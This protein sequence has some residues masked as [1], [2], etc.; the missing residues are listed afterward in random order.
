MLY[1]VYR[2]N[3]Y[4]F[5]IANIRQYITEV[6]NGGLSPRITVNVSWIGVNLGHDGDHKMWFYC[7]KEQEVKRPEV[8]EPVLEI[9][10]KEFSLLAHW[11]ECRNRPLKCMTSNDWL[12]HSNKRQPDEKTFEMWRKALAASIGRKNAVNLRNIDAIHTHKV[13]N[14]SFARNINM[15]RGDRRILFE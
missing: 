9:S 14:I 12:S 2:I 3:Q 15:L 4:T 13:V 1:F 5:E 11:G 7:F 8:L 10:L 6:S